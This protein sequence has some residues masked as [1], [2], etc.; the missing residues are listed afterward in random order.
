MVI[1]T[2]CRY[3]GYKWIGYILKGVG[4]FPSIFLKAGKHFDFWNNFFFKFSK[5]P[6]FYDHADFSN[7][8]AISSSQLNPLK[9]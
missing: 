1:W 5:H 8:E 6:H 7:F 2:I 9:N 3:M 4:Y